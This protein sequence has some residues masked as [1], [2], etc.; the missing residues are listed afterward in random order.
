MTSVVIRRA[1]LKDI[2]ILVDLYSKWMGERLVEQSGFEWDANRTTLLVIKNLQAGVY[3]IAEEGD[4]VVGAIGA[5]LD[6]WM[7]NDYQILKEVY[8]WVDPEQRGDGT[9]SRLITA[10]EDLGR[11]LKVAIVMM[12]DVNPNESG[13]LDMF[14]KNRG[15]KPVQMQYWKWI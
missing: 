11:Q 14:Y 12:Y 7:E 4:R 10:I 15:Y 6:R 13:S 5:T 1:E 8:Y 9:G 2:P 3:F